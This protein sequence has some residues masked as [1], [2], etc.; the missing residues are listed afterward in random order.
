LL[1]I[2]SYTSL[3]RDNESIKLRSIN[4]G[5]FNRGSSNRRGINRGAE[6]SKDT[7][8]DIFLGSNTS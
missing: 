2:L 4:R 3:R 5:D 7:A 8:F 1:L 6:S